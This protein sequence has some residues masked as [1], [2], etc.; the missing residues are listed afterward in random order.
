MQTIIS[1]QVKNN[2]GEFIYIGDVV[3]EKVS[4][5]KINKVDTNES[6]FLAVITDEK[7]AQSR[8]DIASKHVRKI[9]SLPDKG[10]FPFIDY[11][12]GKLIFHGEL[13]IINETE[14]EKL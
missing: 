7:F 10:Q 4:F 11:Q 3:D 9:G 1:E 2:T 5:T 8:L 13:Y 6:P 14:Y 12:N